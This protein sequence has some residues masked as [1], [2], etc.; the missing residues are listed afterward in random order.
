VSATPALTALV[1][2]GSRVGGDPLAAYAGVS[3]KALIDIGGVPMIERVVRALQAAP[4]VA[5]IVICIDRPGL[6]QELPR[7]RGDTPLSLMPT[8]AGPSA[9]VAAALAAQG[10]PL[11]VVTGDHP[12]LRPEWIESFLAD[13]PDTADVCVALARRAAV[14]A[15]VPRTQR[16]WLRFSDDFYSG[17]NLFL[18]R[19]P[20]AR[21]VVELWQ[22]IEAERKKPVKMILRLGPGYALRYLGGRLRLD[23]ALQRLGALSGARL[24]SV[25]IAD[26][27]AA[28]D[29]DKPADLE[30]VRRLI[31]A[32][33]SS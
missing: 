4:S 28:V 3:H 11:L 20:A 15:A 25:D 2:A 33:E 10:T 16:T 18:M 13:A 26:G 7:L 17:C 12:L 23:A 31:A 14:V 22:Q 1:L 5:R 29:V 19:T 6:V 8:A 9:S 24:A 30:L 27:L 21:G 32:R